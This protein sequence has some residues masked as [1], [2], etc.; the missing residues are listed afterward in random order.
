M[1]LT[2]SNVPE[3]HADLCS[4]HFS[5]LNV[6]GLWRSVNEVKVLYPTMLVV[7]ATQGSKERGVAA[8][9]CSS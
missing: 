5:P 8:E 1:G 3:L 7:D 4:R 2:V 9:V 6:Y